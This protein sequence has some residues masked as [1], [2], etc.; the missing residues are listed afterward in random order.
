MSWV[1]QSE[2]ADLYYWYSLERMFLR[3]R[4]LE[5]Y[6]TCTLAAQGPD[7]P[8]VPAVPSPGSVAG[9]SGDVLEG[10]GKGQTARK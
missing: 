2:G 3:G 4:R 5:P 6:V 7:A 1:G 10:V 9:T 8:V